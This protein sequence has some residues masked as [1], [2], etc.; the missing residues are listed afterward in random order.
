MPA[1]PI[2]LA[3]AQPSAEVVALDAMLRLVSP[4]L[5][6]NGVQYATESDASLARR[7]EAEKRVREARRFATRASSCVWCGLPINA[8]ENVIIVSGRAMHVNLC[9]ADF[10]RFVFGDRRGSERLDGAA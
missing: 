1:A 8:G 9:Q 2:F 3:P 4:P 5:T 7:Q 10:D 6:V